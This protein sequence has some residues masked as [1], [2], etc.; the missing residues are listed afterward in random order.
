MKPRENPSE[1]PAPA[2]LLGRCKVCTKPIRTGEEHV[3]L[4]HGSAN[5]L[6]GCASCATKFEANPTAYLVV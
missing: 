4:F 5:Y 3:E 2:G 1:P 6:T